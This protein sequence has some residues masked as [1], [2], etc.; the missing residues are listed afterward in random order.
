MQEAN[1][2]CDSIS[3]WAFSNKTFGQFKI[4][5]GTYHT[6]RGGFN[7]SA[8]MV[9]RCIAKVCDSYK[10]DRAADR[11][12]RLR[13]FRQYGSVAY[14]SR[15]LSYKGNITSIWTVQ[16]RQKIPFVTVQHYAELLKYAQGE[17][18]L[19]YVKGKLYLLQTCD[20]PHENEKSFDDC[21]GADLGLTNIL[22]D[23]D[24]TNYEGKAM[25]ALRKKREKVR[26]SLQ[27]KGT[28]G[29]K[30]VLKRISGRERTTTKIINHTIAKAIVAK[31]KQEQKAIALEDLKAIRDRTNKRLRKSQRGLHNRW[32]FY[33]LRQFVEYKAKL[34]GIPVMVIPAAYTSKTCHKCKRIGNRSGEVF[35]CTNCGVFHADAN[36]AKNIRSWG[37]I[38]TRPE[39]S[40][41]VCDVSYIHASA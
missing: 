32:S 2:A 18:D 4:H 30:K 29:A 7:L 21:I 39:E 10:L 23:S 6:I 12:K 14:D 9:V 16:G 27:S 15:I 25:N 38:I 20:V 13:T 5:H 41:L 36:A 3:E 19:A 17:A 37:R 26:A 31:A 28:R 24:G 22:T 33:Q 34:E 8:Q 40:T 1:D 11:R 35:K